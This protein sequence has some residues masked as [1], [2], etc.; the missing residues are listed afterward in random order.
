M[1]ARRCIPLLPALA[2][3][4]GCALVGG[5]PS[6]APPAT[7]PAWRGGPPPPPENLS[8]PASR[9][10]ALLEKATLH[11]EDVEAAPGG[12]MGVKKA[13]ARFPVTGERIDV[14]WKQ[15][16][17]TTA[18]GW[19]NTPRKELAALAIQKWFLDPH[20]YIVPPS[21]VRCIPLDAYRHIDPDA[22]AT[23]EGTRCVVG[24]LSAWL[25]DVTVPE[26]LYDRD[27]FLADAGY[28]Y[29]MADF[30]V[31]TF[32]VQHRDG[33][34][35]NFLA[36]D[37]PSGRRLFAID[38]GVAF[39]GLVYNYFVDNW[40][41]IRVPAIRRAVVERLRRVRAEHL[42]ALGV[43]VELRADEAGILRPAP[44]SASQ[45]PEA[46]VWVGDGRVQLGLTRAEITAVADRLHALLARVDAG[47]LPVF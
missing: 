4:A 10:G 5:A 24:L 42:E 46:G 17:A 31:L 44:P 18:D 35:G 45:A 33:R 23:I 32:L 43:V 13:V 15:A 41:V 3:T 14:K 40:D 11:L 16:P 21:A 28:A 47:E 30:N 29:H 6:P 22:T 39:G 27:R 25:R 19:N 2:L 20:D 1:K 12:V 38:N 8:L 7:P 9:V 26:R 36:A 34:S 37:G